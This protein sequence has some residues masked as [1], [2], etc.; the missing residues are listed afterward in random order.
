MIIAFCSLLILQQVQPVFLYWAL[1]YRPATN[2][3][4]RTWLVH[5]SSRINVSIKETEP[6]L[7]KW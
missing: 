2:R 4:M 3:N 1:W 6:Q 7:V 5:V